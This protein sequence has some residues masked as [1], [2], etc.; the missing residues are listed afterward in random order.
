MIQTKKNYKK[1]IVILLVI[2]IFVI[3]FAFFKSNKKFF[4]DNL[5]FFKLFDSGLFNQFATKDDEVIANKQINLENSSELFFHVEYDNTDF[6]KINL[7]DTINKDTLVEEKIAPRT[8]G[9]FK[10]FLLSNK[11]IE[12]TINFISL[13]SKPKNLMF[14]IEGRN[15]EYQSLEDLQEDLIGSINENEVKTIS[16]NWYWK[17]DNN[18]KE[19]VQD[20]KD[21]REIQK[22]NFEI[23]VSGVY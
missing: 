4:D 19:D 5:I 8:K 23:L 21:G 13:N 16:I 14:E 20:T 2:V 12:Y 6:K 1:L 7:A 22:Y 9:N 15:E 3:L 11:D 17:Y 18:S 10:I